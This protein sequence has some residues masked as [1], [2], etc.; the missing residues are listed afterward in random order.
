MPRFKHSW[1]NQVHVVNLMASLGTFN[2]HVN[3]RGL[4][5]YWPPTGLQLQ[6]FTLAHFSREKFMNGTEQCQ[7]YWRLRGYISKVLLREAIDT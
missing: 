6:S 1:Q 4:M 3:L 7:F 2:R 5:D